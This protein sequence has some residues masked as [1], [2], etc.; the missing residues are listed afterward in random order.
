MLV[1][2]NMDQALSDAASPETSVEVLIKLSSAKDERVRRAVAANPSLP[3]TQ[4]WGLAREFPE[5]VLSNPILDLLYVA[6]P[7]FVREIPEEAMIR[8]VASPEFPRELFTRAAEHRSLSVRRAVMRRPEVSGELIEKI[9]R[10]YFLFEE[11]ADHPNTPQA[12]QLELARHP[13]PQVR[14]RL[15]N[16][17]AIRDEV[18]AVLLDDGELSVRNA[19]RRN[20]ARRES[21]V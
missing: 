2:Q 5:T 3:L 1:M 11:A 8:L 18:L 13:W 4:L 7:D 19:A 21:A 14:L 15:A 12:Y 20:L 6:D 16:N 17:P 10:G 9:C